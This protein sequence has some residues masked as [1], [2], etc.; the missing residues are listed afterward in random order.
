ML[1]GGIV[2]PI[3]M[4]SKQARPRTRL[5]AAERRRTILDAA[6]EL[7]GARGYEGVSVDQIAAAAGINVSVIYRHVDSKEALH[8][9][10]LEEQWQ[11]LLAY[12]AELI[13]ETPPGRERL[14]VAF[15]SFFE[16]CQ[17]NPLGWRLVFREVGGP[18]AVVAAHERVLAQLSAAIA[19]LLASEDPADP[20]LAGKPGRLIVAEYLKGAMNAVAR[21]W[22]DHP[23]V[24]RDEII[25]LMLDVTWQGF[26]PLGVEGKRRSRRRT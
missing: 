13:V 2:P 15:S 4:T 18:P 3:T 8:A 9:A 17:A 23:E 26:E 5:S 24:S 14:R 16:W 21:W 19:A 22:Y 25:E 12:Q 10:V 1:V 7:F 11:S 20:R 6:L